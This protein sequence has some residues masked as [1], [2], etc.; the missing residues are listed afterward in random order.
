MTDSKQRATTSGLPPAEDCKESGAPQPINPLTGQYADYWVLPA[1]ERAKGFVRP[2]R[3]S[4]KH[5]GAPGPKYDL[6]DLTDE[7]KQRYA[8]TPVPYVKFEKY[9]ESE[10]PVTGRYW[11]QK[12][13]DEAG[14]GCGVVTTMSMAIAETYARQ[15]DYYGST[16]CVGCRA[17]FRVGE[18]GE[19]VWDGDGS[20]VGT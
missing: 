9:P 3:R 17:H 5:V 8:N 20:K 7:E 15:P 11:T 10:S 19:F 2:V 14:K 16:F 12:Q 4:Y 13:L 18:D 1:E 6:H